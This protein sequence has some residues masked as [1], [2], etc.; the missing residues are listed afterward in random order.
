MATIVVAVV[1]RPEKRRAADRRR[2]YTL[3]AEGASRIPLAPERT[4]SG[5]QP[6][7]D[8]SDQT[9][10]DDNR[11]IDLVRESAE[12]TGADAE[13]PVV[14]ARLVQTPDGEELLTAPPF[15]LRP[16]LLGRRLG[17]YCNGLIR[18]L[19][20]WLIACP[21]VRLDALVTPTPP[22]GRDPDDWARW[23]RRVRMRAVDLVIADRRTW[24]PVLVVMLGPAPGATFS[25]SGTAGGT[26]SALVLA[27]GQDRMIDEVLAH[28]GLPLVRGSGELAADWPLIEPYIN[29]TILKTVSEEDL[30]AADHAASPRPDPDAAVKLLK[31]DADGG[32][33][34]D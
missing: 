17:R 27:G 14:A 31:M 18:R 11:L 28:V 12:P 10:F 13:A 29:E 21:R 4:P 30:S 15:A 34:L 26:S 22:D 23:R 25:R 32:W 33:L 6:A 7:T 5:D 1:V 9:A 8:L 3:E 16:H 24:R 20:V 19:P 2:R